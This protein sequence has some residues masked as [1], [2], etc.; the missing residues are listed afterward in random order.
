[1]VNTQIIKRVVWAGAVA[2]VCLAGQAAVAAEPFTLSS[3][4]FKDNTMLATKNAGNAKSNP[5]CIGEN[6]SPPL[7]W[8]NVPAGTKSLALMMTDPEGRGGLGV[9]HW[10]AYGIPVSVTGFAENEVSSAS[11]K[12]IGGKGTAGL[13]T[14]T[15]PC[16]PPGTGFHHYT[17]VMVATDLEPT[18]L[19]PGLTQPELLAKLAGH[20]KGSAGL[21]GLFGRP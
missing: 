14:Y 19:P 6:I 11:D 9:V 15:G 21:V 3:S 17:F 13:N 8:S 1:M 10:L 12:Y 18:E 2:G 16:T 20:S 7:S 5:N 4:T